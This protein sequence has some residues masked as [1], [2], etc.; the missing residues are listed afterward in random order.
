M[1]HELYEI[2]YGI[3]GYAID[4]YVNGRFVATMR[5]ESIHHLEKVCYLFVEDIKWK[6]IVGRIGVRP[7]NR[8]WDVMQMFEKIGKEWVKNYES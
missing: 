5:M 7:T 3:N 2:T 6:N 8:T 4:H 1:N